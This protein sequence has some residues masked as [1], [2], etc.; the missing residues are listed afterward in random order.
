MHDHDAS[1]TRSITR[2]DGLCARPT[3]DRLAVEEPLEIRLGDAPLAVTMRTPGDDLDLAAG[4]CLT[5][6]V[7][8]E[9][10][11]VAHIELDAQ[12]KWGN[13]A[14]VTLTDAAMLQRAE[15]IEAAR[16]Q[17]FVSSSCGL[18]GKQTIDRLM[19][20]LRPLRGDFT[21][22]AA[23]LSSLP[24]K[25][26]RAQSTFDQTGGLHAAALF[27][28]TGELIAL[29]EDVGRHNAVDKVIGHL[30]RE[31]RLPADEAVLIV[32]GRS[33]F[34]I[35]Q[36]AA[37]AGIALIGAVSAP[38]SLAVD[39]A[40]RVGQTLVGFLRENR[41]NMYAHPQRLRTT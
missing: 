32:S 13:I 3:D 17:W 2:L 21:I 19:Q 26:R 8:A 11:D 4:F 24:T 10:G 37:M 20:E 23:T 22:D 41:M 29:R 7:V 40:Q 6:G 5:E 35:M 15:R 36:K 39:F 28:P 1:T 16:R 30:L 18:C 34:E 25:M 27:T 33:S 31:N 12:A 38:S 14:R 9:P